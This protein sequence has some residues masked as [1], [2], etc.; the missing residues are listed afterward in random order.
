[1]DRLSSVVRRF[2]RDEIAQDLIEYTLLLAFVA[3][4]VIAVFIGVG[5]NAQGTWVTANSTLTTANAATATVAT[6]PRG[7]GDGRDG[8]DGG[9]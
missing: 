5:T 2:W 7:D 1:M 6:R 3:L 9:H 8:G 4:G